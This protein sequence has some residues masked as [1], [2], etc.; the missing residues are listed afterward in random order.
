MI[1]KSSAQKINWPQAVAEVTLI[2]TGILVALA[3]NSWWE[4]R[5]ERQVEISYLEALNS[6]FQSNRESLK[7]AIEQQENVINEGDE[8]LKLIKAGLNEESSEEFFSKTGNKLYFFPSWTPVTGTY[9]DLVNSGRLL[10]IQNS[11]LR[12]EMSE[13]HRSLERVRQMERL[14]TETFYAR[15]SPFLVEHQDVNYH[16][17]SKSY[18]PPVSPYSVDIGSFAILKYWNLVVEWIY[19]HADIISN[20]ERSLAYCNRILELIE[21]ELANKRKS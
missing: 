8:V 13:F 2:I 18:K 11:Q 5:L 16:T 10:Y 7:T 9:D 15:Q 20:Y 17:W 21:I 4:D 6:D 14:Q 12:I 3:V 1:A 19:I